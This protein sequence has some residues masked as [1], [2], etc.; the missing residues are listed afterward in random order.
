[1]RTTRR[2]VELQKLKARGS[3][4]NGEFAQCICWARKFEVE[5]LRAEL[6][7][8][9]SGSKV[10]VIEREQPEQA[11]EQQQPVPMRDEQPQRATKMPR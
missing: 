6:N 3:T 5:C 7:A 1:M 2:Q 10:L 9:K 11:Q 8:S 4:W